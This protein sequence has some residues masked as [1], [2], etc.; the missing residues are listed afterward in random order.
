MGV[1][2]A[3]TLLERER[4]L[5]ALDYAIAEAGDARGRVILVEGLAG[6]G[7]TS[8]LAAAGRSAA[9]KG[10]LCLRARATELERDFAYGAVRQLLEA[11]VARASEAERDRLFA[12]AAALSS[13]LFASSA[14]Q[15]TP[16]PDS[17]FAILHG[18]YWL[19]NNIAENQPVVLVVDDIHWADAESVRFFNY[20]APRLDG[21][22]L[23]IAAST[24]V[25][26]AVPPDLARLV[27]APETRVLR[28]RP[29]S[30]GATAIVCRR[31]LEAEVAPEF[32][33]AC[34]KATGGNP[35]FLEA[36]L[37]EVAERGLLPD[38]GSVGV[39][40][41]IGPAEVAEAVLLRVSQARAS[42]ASLVRAVAVLGDGARLADAAR[43]AGLDEDEAAYIADLL[44]PTAIRRGRGGGLE[45]AH[46]IVR[47]AV[48]AEIGA[49]ERA[50]AH[51]EAA[52]ILRQSGAPDE[53][54]AAQICES[55]PAGDHERVDLLR[56]VAADAL[57]RGAP[58]AAVTLLDRALA[59]PPAPDAR[60]EVLVELSS[61]QLRLGVPEA[62]VDQLRE[63]AALVREPQL[64]ATSIRL[65]GGALTW[66]GSADAAVEAI[67]AVLPTIERDDRELAL[68][69]EA[70]RAAYAQQGSLEARALAASWLH[71]YADLDGATAGERLVLASLAFERARVSESES[72]AAA[73]IEG[74]L[75]GDRLLAEQEIDVAGTMYLLVVGLVATD[76]LDALDTCLDAM[77]ADARRRASIPAQAFV[78]VHRGRVALRRGSLSAAEADARTALELL[79]T[80]DIRLGAQLARGILIEAL[81][82]AGDVDDADAVLSERDLG[83]IPPGMA[84]N[85]LLEARGL[86]R[87]AQ[88]R[89]RE[90]LADLRE[91]GT[92]DEVWGAANPLGSRWRSGAALALARLGDGEGARAIAAED[93][94]RARR[95][96]AASG[97]GTALRASALVDAERA[98][99]DGLR[100]AADA[101]KDSPARL[102]Y[103]RALIDLGAALRRD[104]RR[105]EAR[106]PLAEGLELANRCSARDLA[107]RARIELVA[108]GGRSSNPYGSGI[109]QLTASERRVAEF[110]TQGMSNPE[111]AQ[112][113]FVTR[114]TIETHLGRVYR[115][116]DVSG[117]TELASALDA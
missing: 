69:L 9:D 7:K 56:R 114:K 71:R 19:L 27:A 113:L 46:P 59:E 17:G 78:I 93:L 21:L 115:K 10:F 108:A 4:E 58:A 89:P 77:L 90:A 43:L 72:D 31:V 1:A 96:G 14:E 51:A 66:S 32:A 12:G 47:E 39:V 42:A 97:I 112:A 2:T 41:R 91:F 57:R 22:R 67:G 37:R 74:A 68:L 111:I 81:V 98:S 106:G 29:L 63:A 110:A 82:E 16:P 84:T 26:E 79:T 60:G 65:L 61:A 62:A 83:E 86:L 76:A 13:P 49:H 103:A 44:A 109:E 34:R 64:L 3:A 33:A 28:P 52:G 75:Q 105:A 40:Q 116:L 102:E 87:L 94:D 92:R 11:E 104:N 38:A 50:E 8:L 85:L 117:R 23:L 100:D 6:L 15:L 101:L 107:E 45:F 99:I 80:Y 95:W 55:D 53:R 88:E 20:L 70:D 48:Y 54:I 36:L 18:L 35:F 5:R 30:T 25:G 24:R 73:Y